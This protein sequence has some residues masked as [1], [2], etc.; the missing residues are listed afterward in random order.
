MADAPVPSLNRAREEKISE[1]STYFA[2][3]DLSLEEL[4]RR[5][6]R[7][8]KAASMSEL[9][10][11]TADLRSASPPAAMSRADSARL[12]SRPQ[13]QPPALSSASAP[14]RMLSIMSSTRRVGRW[15]VP[16]KLELVGFMAD[17]KMDLTHASLPTGTIEID[18]RL[19]M[20]SFKLVVPPGVSVV[21]EA[22]SILS[23][24]R[25]RANEMPLP[26]RRSPQD[27]PVIRLTGV[28]FMSDVKIVVRRREDVVYEDDD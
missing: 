24:I 6:E 7:V 18:L 14:S 19:V 2:N 4:E 12:Y 22:H 15:A 5:I 1:L 17:T 26:G 3:D 23:N 28:A 11:I 8:Y 25:S 13:G 27:L 20:T 9:A 21:S 10:T 16:R